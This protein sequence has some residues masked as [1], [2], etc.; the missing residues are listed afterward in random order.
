[1]SFHRK[2]NQPRRGDA[3][4]TIHRPDMVHLNPRRG[5]RV[6]L[7][8]GFVGALGTAAQVAIQQAEQGEVW[9]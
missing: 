4:W 1:M 9:Q 7:D 3:A 6:G 8:N 2:H 5:A